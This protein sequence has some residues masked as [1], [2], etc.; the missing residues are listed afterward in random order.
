M[1][2]TKTGIVEGLDMVVYARLLEEAK[3]KAAQRILLQTDGELSE[4]V[5]TDSEETKDGSVAN[6]KGLESEL[7]C[8]SFVDRA[9][10]QYKWLVEAT[11]DKKEFEIWLIDMASSDD[12][13]DK[14]AQYFRGVIS[15][16]KD[17]MGA[18]GKLE[19]EVTFTISGKGK[20]GTTPVPAFSGESSVDYPFKTTEQEIAS[21]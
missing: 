12:N 15:E 11:R 16:R 20:F 14:S 1:A 8:T 10:D 19:V 4:K 21:I 3:N 5:K 2:A 13:S 6:S 17:K 9:S 7:S 18:E